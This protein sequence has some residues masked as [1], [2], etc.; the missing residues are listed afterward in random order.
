MATVHNISMVESLDELGESIL[1]GLMSE[2]KVLV[3]SPVAVK[4]LL[5]KPYDNQLRSIRGV[6]AVW[7]VT[8]RVAVLNADTGTGKTLMGSVCAYLLA[9]GTRLTNAV[10]SAPPTL[11]DK[12][13]REIRKTIPVARVT[14]CLGSTAKPN[15]AGGWNMRSMACTSSS[16]LTPR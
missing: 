13:E 9:Q 6:E 1:D 14:Q 2:A 4:G 3:T 7:N 16:W 10:I 5:R 11:T 8:S 12:W 15:S